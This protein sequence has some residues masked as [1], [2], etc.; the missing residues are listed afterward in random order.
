MHSNHIC[1]GK[2][3]AITTE[4]TQACDAGAVFKGPKTTNRRL[5]DADVITNTVLIDQ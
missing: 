5:G 2:P 3:A 4:I 1:V